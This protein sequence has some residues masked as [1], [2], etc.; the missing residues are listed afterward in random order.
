M[1]KIRFLLSFLIFVSSFS[2]P[3]AFGKTPEDSFVFT[4][5][6]DFGATPNTTAVLEGISGTDSSF[7]L[8]V[9]DL[10]YNQIRPEKAWDDYARAYLR[11]DLPRSRS[12]PAT[13]R[14]TASTGS[15]TI[16]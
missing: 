15:R 12:S 13:M 7:H 3:K 10:S 5:V 16:L 14:K 1:Q 6:G 2:L 9:G 4:A 11:K 8:A